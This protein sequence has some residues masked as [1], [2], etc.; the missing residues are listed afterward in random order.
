MLDSGALMEGFSFKP[1]TPKDSIT[2]FN[3]VPYFKY[4][5]SSA[6]RK[7]LPRRAMMVL[8]DTRKEHVMKMFQRALQEAAK[9]FNSG[10]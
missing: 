8:D 1:T 9:N 3:D 10:F 6:P 7:K 2:L 5:Q 4:H